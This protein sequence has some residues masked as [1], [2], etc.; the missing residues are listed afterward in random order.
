MDPID[1]V[2]DAIIAVDSRTRRKKKKHQIIGIHANGHVRV[3]DLIIYIYTYS[4]QQFNNIIFG[5]RF[6][7]LNGEQ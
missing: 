5:L 1:A 3:R 4:T 7:W 6:I 2:C